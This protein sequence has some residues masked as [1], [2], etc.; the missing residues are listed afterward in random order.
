MI[1]RIWHG[2]VKK[3]KSDEYFGYLN[4]TGAADYRETD[5]NRGV[6]LFRRNEKAKTHYVF[7]TLWDSYES[8]RKFA[9]ED[10]EKAR[11]YPGDKD[12]LL[13]FE[14]FVTHYEVLIHPEN[15][16]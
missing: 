14:E 7:L 2:V 13:E 16:I 15:E 6:F 12:F 9:G 8:I 1:A 11:Y 10:Y 5:G 3:S 4:K